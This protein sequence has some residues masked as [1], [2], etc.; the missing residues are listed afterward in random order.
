[1]EDSFD[2]IT[3]ATAIILTVIGFTLLLIFTNSADLL[4]KGANEENQDRMIATRQVAGEKEEEASE[5]VLGQTVYMEILYSPSGYKME[6]NATNLNDAKVNVNGSEF[7]YL[8]YA[9]YAD[10]SVLARAISFR[11][12]YNKTYTYDTSGHIT[13]V[14]YILN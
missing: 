14:S 8:D 3:V 7:S 10:S 9:R 1:M 6:L 5:K 13:G 4:V 11:S 2:I 12:T